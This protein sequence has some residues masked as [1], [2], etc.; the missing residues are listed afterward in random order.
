MGSLTVEE[1]KH[2]ILVIGSGGVG[3]MAAYALEKGGKAE[4]TAVLR[5]NFEAVEESGFD[6]K[7]IDHGPEPISGWRPSHIRNTIPDVGNMFS[8][9]FDFIVVTT[10]NLA[11]IPPSVATLI[12]PA[13][14]TGKTVIALLQ[15]GINIERPIIK[16]FPHNPVISGVP[17][18]GAIENPPGTIT[19]VNHDRLI[20][21]PFSNENI[22]VKRSTAAAKDFQ[23]AYASCPNVTCTYEPRVENARWKKLLYN[24]SYNTIAAILQ[25]DTSRMRASEFI[26][27]DLVRPAMKEIQA[28][29]RTVSGV[30]LSDGLIETII[31][32]DN[33]TA[34]FRPSMLQ[35]ITKGRFIEL[36]NIL[37]E[38]LREADNAGVPTPTLKV[39]YSLLKGLQFKTKESKGLVKVSPSGK[40][41]KYG[42][43]W[44][45]EDGK[46]NGQIG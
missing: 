26:I 29:A 7:S 27:D 22:S 45:D 38:P 15:N 9:P 44:E 30:D 18:I 40:G 12:A 3:T 8:R 1:R 19:H 21:S 28:T 32:A 14:T 5:S 17:Y 24:A 11:D 23:E 42:K 4:V 25:M 16:A 13:I 34:F 43:R 36:E 2:N 41:L 10:K 33:Y 6:I 31:R 46:K 35:D 37:G 20:I 39:I